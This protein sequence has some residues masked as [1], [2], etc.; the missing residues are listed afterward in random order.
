MSATAFELPKDSTSS[1]SS[2]PVS[3][4][5]EVGIVFRCRRVS[6]AAPQ[7]E[8]RGLSPD[9]EDCAFLCSP[10][11]NFEKP[12][13]EVWA[14]QPKE[15]RAEWRRRHPTDSEGTPLSD[16]PPLLHG[17]LNRR[18]VCNRSRAA[19]GRV[20]RDRVGSC[21]RARI[22][23][24]IRLRVAAAAAGSQPNGG[25]AQKRD[26]AEQAH[27]ALARSHRQDNSEQPRKQHSPQDA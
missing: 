26:Q 14:V 11:K 27:T 2:E 6:R 5:N 1:P 20:D 7:D 3:E 10:R 19:S 9:R 22:R 21:R 16:L 23:A 4:R 8:R 17:E 18:G 12:P 15:A 24:R 13:L 25:E